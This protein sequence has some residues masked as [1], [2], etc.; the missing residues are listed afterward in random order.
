[1]RHP[2][3]GAAKRTT[4]LADPVDF[5]ELTFQAEAGLPYHLWMR[6]RADDDHWA[7]DSV[8]VQFSNASG[9]AIGSSGA[10]TVNLEDC[11]GCGISGW[12]WQDNGW[13]AGVA[14]PHV[15]FSTGGLQTIRVQ[16]REDG[17]SIDQIIL[18]PARFLTDAPGALK[19]DS[20]TYPESGGT[21]PPPDTTAPVVSIA[22]PAPGSIVSGAVVVTVDATDNVRVA[23]VELWVDGALT[24]TRTA[25]PFTFTW[26]ASAAGDGAHVLEARAQ[27][28]SGNVAT[29][30]GVDVTVDG[31]AAG[32]GEI[33]LY[34]SNATATAGGWQA[35][36]D[37]S[38]AGGWAMYQADAGAAKRTTALAEPDD[39][40]ELTFTAEAGVPYHLWMRARA[41][42]D[43]WGNDSVHV[44]FSGTPGYAIG[45]T[46]AATVNLEDC[47]GCGLSGWGWQDN[48]WGAGING[49]HIEFAT[50]GT[51][52]IRIQT[53]EDGLRIDQ[54]VLSP[55]AFLTDPPGTLKND[56]TILSPP[57]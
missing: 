33:I 18:S 15:V 22:S 13:G 16:T 1:M 3:G 36:A 31:T 35:V 38:A 40:F 51:Q 41:Q 20:T 17:L 50:G 57:E 7:N 28:A 44:Q 55:A 19:N 52:T 26:D 14:G 9:A 32:A 45:T 46:S 12:G 21:P 42:G 34:A 8:F 10:E 6:G 39:Y 43:Y 37:P 53:R 11:S 30:A 24:A 23:E 5:F 47:S 48:G 56:T 4:A 2:N 25:A 29:S 27:D 54:I 49:P